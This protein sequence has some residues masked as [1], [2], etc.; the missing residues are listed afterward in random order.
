MIGEPGAGGS[1]TPSMVGAV[2]RWRKEKAA[3]A[4]PVWEAL[5]E[6]N[7]QVEEGLSQLAKCAATD[8]VAYERTLEECSGRPSHEVRER[9]GSFETML[10]EVGRWA[11]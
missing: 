4:Q 1:S 5:A 2:Q 6:A 9:D 11:V 3:A 10:V 7:S 8:R